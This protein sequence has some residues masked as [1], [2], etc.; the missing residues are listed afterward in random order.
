MPKGKPG[1]RKLFLK[2]KEYKL[3]GSGHLLSKGQIKII[4]NVS[5]CVLMIH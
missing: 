5:T 2:K 1:G 4:W 3:Q